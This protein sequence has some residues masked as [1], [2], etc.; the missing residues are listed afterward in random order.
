MVVVGGSQ[1]QSQELYGYV[2]H[3]I[4][5][6][7]R[8][9]NMVIGKPKL[10]RTNFSNGSVIRALPCSE[11]KVRGPHPN[12][13]LL[14]EV[15]AADKAGKTEVINAAM[16]S[17][18]GAGLDEIPE[19]RIALTSTAHHAAGK[20]VDI[21]TNAKLLGYNRYKWAAA[22]VDWKERKVTESL[23]PW[24]SKDYL[25]DKLDGM[26]KEQFQVEFMA[27][28]KGS[29][30][31]VF[32][33]EDID[34]A[35]QA[36]QRKFNIHSEGIRIGGIDWASARP[37]VVVIVEKFDG[38]WWVIDAISLGKRSVTERAKA[39][40]QIE[41]RYRVDEFYAD[42]GDQSANSRVMEMGV[43]VKAVN[44]GHQKNVMMGVLVRGFEGG[45]FRMPFNIR[46][47]NLMHFYQ[48]LKMYHYD[49]KEKFSKGNDDYID[50]FA[51][52]M[53]PFRG[54]LVTAAGGGGQMADLGDI[55][56]DMGG[57]EL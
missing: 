4:N 35:I 30:S 38:L 1:E 39:I 5:A 54:E 42:A 55:F 20:F 11:Q 21:W 53:Y 45:F 26:V 13:L 40:R 33:E 7:P 24:I 8:L 14:D 41:K 49:A 12:I 19:P 46:S 17:M 18:S 6:N 52:A 9:S 36:D 47:K 31:R 16:N 15:A 32:A 51:L 44:F 27:E 2:K 3:F 48:Q 29:M 50:S 34:A 10:S 57:F 43:N 56:E 37:T 22:V 28:L 25:Q 23:I